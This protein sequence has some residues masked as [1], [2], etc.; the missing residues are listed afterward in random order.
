MCVIQPRPYLLYIFTWK[1][2]LIGC[3]IDMK[4]GWALN[5]IGWACPNLGYATALL[6]INE[7]IKNLN[8]TN[9]Q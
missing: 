2:T 7:D 8:P 6:I 5:M 9:N 4:I 1:G 3:T